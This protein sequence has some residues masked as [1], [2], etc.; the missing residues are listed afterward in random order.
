MHWDFYLI[1]IS[2]R[3][4]HQVGAVIRSRECWPRETASRPSK[5]WAVLSSSGITSEYNGKILLQPN[6][7]NAFAR[8]S[9]GGDGTEIERSPPLKPLISYASN[10]LGSHPPQSRLASNYGA[11]LIRSNSREA[12]SFTRHF[13]AAL[14]LT[15]LQLRRHHL[16]LPKRRARARPTCLPLEHVSSPLQMS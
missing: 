8:A 15:G 10:L 4:E 6:R 12:P 7:E 1:P 13:T 11:A 5:A 9:G 3:A 2:W 16:A 14:V